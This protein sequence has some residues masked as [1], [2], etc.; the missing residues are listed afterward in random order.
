MRPS[1]VFGGSCAVPTI[2][3]VSSRVRGDA[4]GDIIRAREAAGAGRGANSKLLALG[5]GDRL[6]GMGGGDGL[7]AGM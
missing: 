4:Y 5:A 6:L 2:G 7:L 3:G 1:G